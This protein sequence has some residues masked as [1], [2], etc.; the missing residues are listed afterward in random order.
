MPTRWLACLFLTIAMGETNAA[1]AQKEAAP[2]A[3]VDLYRS[4]SEHYKAGRYREAIVDLKQALALDP[5]SPNLVYN[6]ARVSELLGNLGEAIDYYNIYLE[7]LDSD[8]DEERQGIEQTIRRLDGARAELA[9]NAAAR[10]DLR[11]PI[12]V[13]VAPPPLGN[14]DIW[15]WAT[16]GTGVAALLVGAVTGIVALDSEN[17]VADFKVGPDGSI[18]NRDK[19]VTDTQTLALVTDLLLIGGAAAVLSAAGLY[20]FRKPPGRQDEYSTAARIT[21]GRS[22]ATLQLSGSF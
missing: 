10:G 2:E 18:A 20:F 12:I 7:L 4:G 1:H 8:D 5:E 19:L 13:Q 3:A 14:A 22:G 21:L 16:A 17:R 9:E 6:V 15:F 11:E